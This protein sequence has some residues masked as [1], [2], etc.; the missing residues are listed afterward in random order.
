[1]TV[2]A[3]SILN[4]TYNTD[5]GWAAALA[6]GPLSP[7]GAQP[8]LFNYGEMRYSWSGSSAV[9]IF[10]MFDTAC[11]WDQAIIA[12]YGVISAIAPNAPQTKALYASSWSPDLYNAGTI[13]AEA[14]SSSIA[15]E[16]WDSNLS[17][18]NVAGGVIESRAQ[19][20]AFGLYLANGGTVENAGQILASASGGAGISTGAFGISFT[21]GGGS[22]VHNSG[23]I[24]ASDADKTTKYA[25]AIIYYEFNVSQIVNDGTLRGD[26]AIKEVES[27]GSFPYLAG[28][29]VKNNGLMDGDIYLG[30]GNDV[31]QNNGNIIGQVDL[32]ADDDIYDGQLG[33]ISGDLLG[34]SGNDRLNGGAGFEHLLGGTGN[35][36][37]SGGGGADDL[38]GGS[39]ADAFVYGAAS[40]STAA[41]RDRIRDFQSG[42]DTIELRY[43]DVSAINWSQH[44]DGTGTYNIVDISTASG[45]ISIRVDG[46]LAMADFV[47]AQ[48]LNLV[49][50]SGNDTLT[51]GVGNDILNGLGGADQMIG[52]AGNDIYYVD[53]NGDSIVEGPA[54]GF[55]TAFDTVLASVS[56][57]LTAGAYVEALSTTDQTGK[58]ALDLTGNTLGQ[59]ITGNQG[60]NRID[61]GGGAD[62]LIGLGGDDVY[63]VD[64][65]DDIVREAVGGGNDT[66]VA[67][68]HYT[69]T[70]GAEV[71]FL[72]T[73][74]DNGTAWINLTGNEF[75]Q[76]LRGN[77]A[78]N[79]LFGGGGDDRLYGGGG[80]DTLGGGE[81]RDVYVY[82]NVS[83]S[84]FGSSDLIFLTTG[85]DIIDLRAVNAISVS[86]PNTLVQFPSDGASVLFGYVATVVTPGGNM[87]LKIVGQP[88]RTDFL[89]GNEIV[90]SDFADSLSGTEGADVIIGKGG[91][92]H[93]YGLGGIDTI[94]G[95]AGNDVI[96]G[97]AGADAMAGG[98]GND[99]FYVDDTGD[100]V[101]ELGGE[102]TDE[103]RTSLSDYTLPSNVEILTATG[104]SA[105]QTLRGNAGD[106]VVTGSGQGDSFHLEQ[107]G[108]DTANGGAGDDG[109]FF[110]AA[111]TTADH[112]DGGAGNND[113]IGLQGD[114]SGANAL[115]LAPDT[116]TGIEAIVV[117][118][119]FNYSLTTVEANVTT[120]GV[121]KVQATQLAAGQSLTFNGSAEHD[122]AFMVFG[123]QGDD[124]MT[125]GAGNDGFYFGPGGFSGADMVD[126]GPGSNDQLAL[127]GDY[128]SAGAPFLLGGN[129]VNTE[130]LVL[131]PG[132][133]GIPNHFNL[134]GLDTFVTAGKM[135]T[136]FGLQVTTDIVF[137]GGFEHDGAF[138]F[139]GGAGNDN[140]V[141]SLGGDWLFGGGGGDTLT[142]GGGADTFFYDDVSQST[143]ASYDRLVGFDAAVD[144]IDLP[145]IVGT[146]AV[147]TSGTL[148]SAGMDAAFA[149]TFGGLPYHQ[150]ALFTATGGDMAG[151]I[152]LVV[153]A[154]GIAGYQA[155]SDYV[156][157]M[158]SPTAPVD[159]PAIFI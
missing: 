135:M 59:T 121:L 154:D 53:D 6:F 68:T 157:E 1:M 64:S 103:V 80:G 45:T 58:A 105:G 99:V 108:N 115:V 63:I 88:S 139:Y 159:N 83:E 41:A 128:G 96:D 12:N 141:G 123:G 5:G 98:T 133:A 112:V 14:K 9:A 57:T 44:T 126:G 130:V 125:G 22:S 36:R 84:V 67:A 149:S 72:V 155:G 50:T 153:D 47:I 81:G 114:Y 31:L 152:F 19:E 38:E 119:G 25:A 95:Q 46:A 74:D 85:E 113:Q 75:G 148:N 37:L 23:L 86:W 73:P 71:E 27:S 4:Y 16:S 24:Q 122:G 52:N 107:G 110:G 132:P 70:A 76:V 101:T 145:F 151:R 10:I 118:P 124:R 39:G 144:R 21:A 127:D 48:D 117:L 142:G 82:L 32:G 65:N 156:I 134:V 104:S 8:S 34:G 150:A 15:Y 116:I 94:V 30:K 49:G 79:G 11:F 3:D 7:S 77:A 91:D 42:V 78:A 138:K 29:F 17:V 28:I 129:V 109:F 87:T 136:I 62:T 90:G 120:G 92:D 35:D 131:L 69:L 60:A 2:S 40:D 147:S 66:V 143:S 55:D 43:L 56:Y 51:G 111:F 106:N 100:V 102:G 137:F 33:T 61:G 54:Q 140:V 13:T 26:Y 18:T 146:F 93:L 20:Q 97:G 89:L 158:V